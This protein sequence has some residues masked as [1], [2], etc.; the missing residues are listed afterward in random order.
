MLSTELQ[1]MYSRLTRLGEIPKQSDEQIVNDLKN[2][3][4]IVRN[5]A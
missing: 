1:E 4:S 3:I 5:Q 2:G